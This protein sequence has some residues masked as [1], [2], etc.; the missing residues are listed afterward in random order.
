[1]SPLHGEGRRFEPCIDHRFWSASDNQRQMFFFRD[2][3]FPGVARVCGLW[4]WNRNRHCTGTRNVKDFG[5]GCEVRSK[6]CWRGYIGWE[7]TRLDQCS[8]AACSCARDGEFLS[9]WRKLWSYG[10]WHFPMGQRE[11]RSYM[12]MKAP[13]ECPAEKPLQEHRLRPVVSARP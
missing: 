11:A 6:V 7:I 2:G 1:M 13:D 12:A 4:G 5:G 10:R 3:K 8:G 9:I